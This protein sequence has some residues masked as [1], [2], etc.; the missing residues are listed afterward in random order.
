MYTL[1]RNKEGEIFAISADRIE[2]FPLA[3]SYGDHGQNFGSYDAGDYI[4]IETKAAADMANAWCEDEAEP[5]NWNIGDTI[6]APEKW[7]LFQ[8]MVDKPGFELSQLQITGFNYHDGHNWQT[9]AVDCDNGEEQEYS[10]CDDD[11]IEKFNAEIEDKE[12][13]KKTSFGATYETESFTLFD[14]NS[15]SDWAAYDVSFRT[16]EA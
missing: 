9:I 14:G 2:R 10:Y 12:Q 16:V 4:T 13:V 11:L 5:A 7:S 15:A 3:D 6:S 1:I 8:A